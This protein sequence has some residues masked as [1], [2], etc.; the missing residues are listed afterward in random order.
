MTG[1]SIMTSKARNHCNRMASSKHVLFIAPNGV[2]RT[3]DKLKWS[4]ENVSIILIYIIDHKKLIWGDVL[5]EKRK[6]KKRIK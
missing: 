6:N 1:N 4:P 3:F 2:G 5:E